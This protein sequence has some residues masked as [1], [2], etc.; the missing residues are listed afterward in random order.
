GAAS[1]HIT[2]EPSIGI[3]GSFDFYPIWKGGQGVAKSSPISMALEL[4]FDTSMIYLSASALGA[5]RN[6]FGVNGITIKDVGIEAGKN[7]KTFA[8]AISS[9]I[10]AASA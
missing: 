8:A 5:W 6:P 7:Y 10:L 9:G 4:G 2:S 3:E 1:I